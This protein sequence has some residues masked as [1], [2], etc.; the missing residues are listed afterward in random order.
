MKR[1]ILHTTLLF[2]LSFSFAQDPY[3]LWYKKPAVDWQSEALP[4]GNGTLGASVMGGVQQENIILNEDSLW[5][6]NENTRGAYSTGPT[7]DFGSF[8]PFGTLTVDLSNQQNFSQ[9]TRKLNILDGVYTC[10]YS[11]N[12]TEFTREYFVSYPAKAIILHY[13]ANKKGAYAG[14]FSLTN[15]N[16]AKIS[17]KDNSIILEGQLANGLSF[18]GKAVIIN[19][20]GSVTA[21]E[22][23]LE[24][25]DADAITVLICLGTSYI[26]DPSKKWKNDANW[27][28]SKI[29][30]PLV[31]A[32]K[33]GFDK[34][35]ADH[36]KDFGGIMNRVQLDIGTTI[37]ELN[38][39][40]NERLE[41]YQKNPVDPDLVET[42][43][44]YGRY[45]LLSSSRENS[46]PANLQGLWNNNP[47]PPLG[48]DYHMGLNLQMSYWLAQTCNLPESDQAL[49]HFI[50]TIAGTSRDRTAQKFQS[51]DKEFKGWLLR[52]SQNIYGGQGKDW[53]PTASA[54][55][56]S[57]M[58]E[59]Y[60]FSLNKEFLKKEAYPLM[61]E[62][63]EFWLK[64]LKSLEANGANFESS[65]EQVDK[66]QLQ[67]V[68]AGTLVVPKSLSSGN[69]LQ[70]DGAALEN[71]II[72][73]LLDNTAQAASVLGDKAFAKTLKEAQS[74][75]PAPKIG[76]WG[77][78]ME[79]MIDRDNQEDKESFPA[80]LFAVYPGH[81]I[82]LKGTPE[83][84]QA[85]LKT[86]EV[87][88]AILENKQPWIW[89]WRAAIWARLGRGGKAYADI[90]GL[91][92]YNT[93]PNLITTGP[94][95]RME[96]NFGITAAIAE[97][98]VQSQNGEI[99]FL[100]AL[101]KAW[102]NG[103]IKGLRVRGDKSVEI[104]WKDGKLESK[105]VY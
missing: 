99:E 84:A 34:L 50:Q 102:P 29:D 23:G 75:L 88:N 5:S 80:H 77:Q 20:G 40:T 66:S 31:E 14:T 7:G 85:A 89:A 97:M 103:S 92:Q 3:T 78:L 2:G 33:V 65:N 12:E 62:T 98:L 42:M 51:E 76:K 68:V 36:V 39:P 25:K 60:Q 93:M 91:L 9:Y 55:L 19:E 72:W 104:S 30:K 47:N 83:L 11:A 26:P 49:I 35:K 59:Y 13:A 100:P 69:K 71:Q 87:K 79:W 67:G 81:Q 41:A 58:W 46:L 24:V 86:M 38:I 6:G 101:P 64:H 4:L 52:T 63:A 56:V 32:S 96:G 8:Q 90:K 70:E 54:W 22:K 28:E 27:V 16:Q 94:P 82:S 57:H 44:Q 105:K 1:F 10:N 43:F 18:S 95:M 45:L 48:S 37:K 53:N 17:Y 74:K 61:K 15:P 73:N 21:T